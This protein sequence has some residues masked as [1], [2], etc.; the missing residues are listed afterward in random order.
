MAVLIFVMGNNA[1]GSGGVLGDVDFPQ[2][3]HKCLVNYAAMWQIEDKIC[4]PFQ[5]MLIIPLLFFKQL[6]RF[7]YSYFSGVILLDK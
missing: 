1:F 2:S 6:R 4:K 3:Y 7:G 5:V